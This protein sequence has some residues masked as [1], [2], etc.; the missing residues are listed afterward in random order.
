MVLSEFNKLSIQKFKGLYRRGLMDEVPPDHAAIVENMAFSQVGE[1]STRPGAVTSL[2]LTHPVKRM[3]LSTN[4]QGYFLLT[5][6]YSGKLWS[7]NCATQV[8]SLLKD[9]ALTT[10][11]F[12][13]VNMFGKTFVQPV[14]ALGL[15][16]GI[17]SYCVYVFDGTHFRPALGFP[18]LGTESGGVFS[19]TPHAG[20]GGSTSPGEYRMAV[21][22]ITDTGYMTRPGPV[23]WT[24]TPGTWTATS[25]FGPVIWIS[26]GD[27]KVDLTHI[28]VGDP[29]K[30]VI[31]RQ[32]LVTKS[33]QQEFFFLASGY[34]PDNTTTSLT[35]DWFDTDLA[36]SA[37]Y[38]FDN[39][40]WL[41]PGVVQTG[42]PGTE[43]G[44]FK[45]H[46]RLFVWGNPLVGDDKILVSEAGDPETFSI[47]HSYIQMP[48]DTD[49]NMVR[50]MG[51]LRDTLY[52]F[53]GVGIFSTQDTLDNPNTWP[54]VRVDG[55]SGAWYHSINTISSAQS[56]IPLGD[57]LVIGDRNGLYVFNGVVQIPALTWKVN[58]LWRRIPK[59]RMSRV[60]VDIDPFDSLIY[61]LFPIDNDLL[62]SYLLVGDFSEGLN[63]EMIKWSHYY[64]PFAARSIGLALIQDAF[65]Y[66]YY[67]RIGSDDNNL[68]RINRATT[69]GLSGDT[70]SGAVSSS[71]KTA[72]IGLDG[73][74]MSVFRALVYR[75]IVGAGGSV[76]SYVGGEDT[77]SDSSGT[78][79]MTQVVTPSLTFGNNQREHTSQI[80]MTAEKIQVLIQGTTPFTLNRIDIYGK[81]QFDAR[82]M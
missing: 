68:Y 64:F 45:Y 4:V 19:A 38:L 3:F 41:P 24:G 63:W 65:D 47:V 59:D 51:I 56:S 75:M 28:P 26:P 8:D 37:D 16:Y 29:A 78:A 13:A 32:I 71:Y 61:V 72:L 31:A 11:D 20:G 10:V 15:N 23:G 67:I 58:D 80:N 76:L 40:D 49:A 46:G 81:T 82:P 33:D 7:Y 73:G 42:S 39:R 30:G 54:I 52:L 70:L 66:E 2:S 79:L 5:L 43:L 1:V 6:D 35:L 21:C 57:V 62:P 25:N 50:G 53:R 74:K 27:T 48:T 60:T 44:L 14:G 69:G 22:F 12:A 36:I 17:A 55:A 18:P 77:L 34:I 9:F